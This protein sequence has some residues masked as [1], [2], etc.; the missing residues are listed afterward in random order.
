M[1]WPSE[2][3]LTAG[4]FFECYL[5]RLRHVP[6]EEGE[7]DLTRICGKPGNEKVEEALSAAS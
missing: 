7:E 3:F 5:V 4:I 1:V 6:H 2:E